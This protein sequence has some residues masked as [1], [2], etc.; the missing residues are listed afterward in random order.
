MLIFMSKYK[1]DEV[2]KINCTFMKLKKKKKIIDHIG[3]EPGTFALLG[4]RPANWANE[5]DGEERSI[6]YL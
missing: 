6:L 3:F 5:S 4:P 1:G 2:K